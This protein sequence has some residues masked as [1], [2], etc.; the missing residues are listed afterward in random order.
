MKRAACCLIT[1]LFLSSCK[2]AEVTSA[3]VEAQLQQILSE[4][5]TNVMTHVEDRQHRWAIALMPNENTTVHAQFLKADEFLR[6]NDWLKHQCSAIDSLEQLHAA[7]S[8]PG[9]LANTTKEM[10]VSYRAFREFVSA[11]T[12]GTV[13]EY[14]AR[15]D[16]ALGRVKA[17]SRGIGKPIES[18]IE[19]Y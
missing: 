5:T 15:I 9:M 19:Y 14:M 17:A 6:S 7:M 11:D 3:E 13:Q 16:V 2:H 1:M 12:T 10:L 18:T 8:G 4:A